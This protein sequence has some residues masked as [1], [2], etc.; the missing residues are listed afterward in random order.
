MQFDGIVFPGQGT[1]FLGMGKDFVELYEEAKQVFNIAKQSINTDLYSICQS[2]EAKLNNTEYTQP[3]IVALEIA[4]YRALK[5]NYR[6]NPKFFCWA[7][8]RRIFSISSS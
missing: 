3:C 7:F 4:M 2:D 1:Q 5:Q 8:F 6:I